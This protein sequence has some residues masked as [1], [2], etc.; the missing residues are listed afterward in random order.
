MDNGSPKQPAGVASSNKKVAPPS[1]DLSYLR[2]F[3]EGRPEEHPLWVTAASGAELHKDPKNVFAKDPFQRYP[4]K[5]LNHRGGHRLPPR[6]RVEGPSDDLPPPH[7][8]R[9]NGRATG[10]NEKRENAPRRRE[11]ALFWNRP[12]NSFGLYQPEVPRECSPFV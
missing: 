6:E 7:P 4:G 12:S 8:V 3:P 9:N 10:N 1:L 11:S 5:G 2:G